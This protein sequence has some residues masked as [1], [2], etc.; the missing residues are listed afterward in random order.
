MTFVVR[1]E[2]HLNLLHDA[3]HHSDFDSFF[4]FKYF[5]AQCLVP[6][7]IFIHAFKQMTL[8]ANAKFT[9]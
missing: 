2:T 8:N 4:F 1:Q 9:L 6:A 5:G 3:F 7:V